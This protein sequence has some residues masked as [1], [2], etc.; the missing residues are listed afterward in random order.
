MN[1]L[2][3]EIVYPFWFCTVAV[4][5]LFPSS[6]RFSRRWPPGKTSDRWPAP[7]PAGCPRSARWSILRRPAYFPVTGV[8]HQ[9]VNSTKA[10]WFHAIIA[11]LLFGYNI[12]SFHPLAIFLGIT[13]ISYIVHL[14]F[15]WRHIVS[16][17]FRILC[18]L[19]L[20][21]WIIIGLL[22]GEVWRTELHWLI[23][24]ASIFF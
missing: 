23:T 8:S 13:A 14:K 7:K 20:V 3:S 6:R 1:L 19:W 18:F 21:V 22:I 24:G 11:I 15:P 2:I 5:S 4:V 10:E 9:P 17:A 16:R 12:H